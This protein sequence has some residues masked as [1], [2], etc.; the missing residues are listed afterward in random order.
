MLVIII[1]QIPMILS[2]VQPVFFTLDVQVNFLRIVP[3][4][5]NFPENIL[6]KIRLL[7]FCYHIHD[8]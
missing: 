1:D 2:T 7:F 5:S 8:E 3:L 6:S 4:L